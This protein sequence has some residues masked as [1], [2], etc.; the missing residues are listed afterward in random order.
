MIILFIFFIVSSADK[1]ILDTIY[2]QNN[3]VKI[4][5]AEGAGRGIFTQKIWSF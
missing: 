1:V 5:S 2:I 4:N 3:V